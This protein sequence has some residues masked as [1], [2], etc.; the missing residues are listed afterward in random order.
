MSRSRQG[1]P[2]RKGPAKPRSV[3]AERIYPAP[4]RGP[5]RHLWLPLLL[6]AA[7]GAVSQVGRVQQNPVLV[8]SF[9]ATVASLLA[10]QGW[11]FLRLRG[12]AG[13]G[14][15]FPAFTTLLR[16]QHYIQAALQLT[17]Y[18]YWGYFWRPV[19]DYA[20]LMLAQF[21]FA[22]AF[23]ILLAWSRDRPFQLG[24]GPLPIILSTNL[25]LWFRDDWFYLQF[26]MIAV[27]FLGKEFV[28]WNREGR[29][30]HIFNPSAF[31]LGL[32]SV[33]LIVT[34]ST[35]LTWG[36]D[37]ATTL[38][39]GPNIY[40]L[41]F[42]VGLVAMFSFSITLVTGLAALVLFGWS[43]IYG[44][45]TGVPYFVDSEI[46]AAVFLGLHLL[47][48]D[49]STSPRTPL[50]KAVFGLMYGA[51]VVVL[52]A[53]L[54][55]L[56]A[57]TFYD[58][59]LAV[60]LL[61]LSVQRIDAFVHRVQAREWWQRVSA[62]WSP[63]RLNLAQMA[64]WGVFFLAMTA[65]GRTD[66]RHVG[67]TLPFWQQA[68]DEGRRTACDRLLQIEYSYCAD[69]S[70]WACNEL[71]RHLREGRI[72][73][74][75]PELALGYFARACEGRFQAGCVNLLDPEGLV[76]ALPRPLDLRVVLREGG[77]NLSETPEP[78][79][80]ARACEHG[81]EYACGTTVSHAR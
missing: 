67:D 72:V 35:D 3:R 75:D 46:P 18:A 63:P 81:W 19:Y 5:L 69:N 38:S 32:F 73:D 13:E 71:G 17:V 53:V 7:L 80:L 12:G 27:G 2:A 20:W 61:N 74:A 44:A 6:T 45:A 57:P 47:V 22:Y 65:A 36:V 9:A 10:W 8:W 58:K 77:I 23:S 60:P 50:G 49:P 40:M 54:G 39:I 51:S 52:F 33:V 76:S 26:L 31:S 56:G 28:R 78:E 24:F 16:P 29:K 62:G 66:G 21:I 11:L 30:V 64:V 70:G 42:L 55:A 43:A 1:S 15:R 14:A 79:L 25:F 48:T 34:G 41:L 4:E 59:L 68:C 37:I